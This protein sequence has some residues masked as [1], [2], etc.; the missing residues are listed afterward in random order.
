MM[1][2]V[3]NN[4]AVIL[5][6]GGN[7]GIGYFMTSQFLSDGHRVIVFDLNLDNLQ[8]LKE[9]YNDNLLLFECDVCDPERV[10]QSVNN[11]VSILGSIDYAIHNA[12]K[13][14]FTS[15]EETTDDDYKS[16]FDVNY[17]GAIN[18]TRA[19]LPSMKEKANGRIFYT[20]SGVGVMGFINIS[21]YASSKGALESL[22]KCMNIEHR[23]TGIS[24]HLI[25]PPL[26]K[27]TSANPLP[28]PDEIK[29][30][31]EK[32]GVGIAKRI[33]KKNFIICHSYAQQVQTRMAYMFPIKLG[34]FMSKMTSRQS[35]RE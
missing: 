2:F 25:H 8:P 17:Y 11:A 20:S 21:A 13:C 28:V 14:L 27:T 4:L 19:V 23:G 15:I 31:P 29:A 18:L 16:V 7:E 34:K 1:C 35:E 30:D 10:T 26:T 24:F 5:I 6:A 32:V 22:A 9:E 3:E 33:H 12:C